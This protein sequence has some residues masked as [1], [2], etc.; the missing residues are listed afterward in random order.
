MLLQGLSLEHLHDDEWLAFVLTN[1]VNGANVRMVQ[2]RSGASLYQQL[3]DGPMILGKLIRQK[4]K[5][6]ESAKSQILCFA[7]HPHSTAT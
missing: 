1:I 5:G 2:S 6:N 7:N 3:L 4:L